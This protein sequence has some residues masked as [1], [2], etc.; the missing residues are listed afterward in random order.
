M[1]IIPTVRGLD[2]FVP[3]IVGGVGVK[4]IAGWIPLGKYAGPVAVAG[5][6][7]FLKNDVL[8]TLGGYELGK[9]LVDGGIGSTSGITTS[10]S[11]LG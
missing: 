5:M 2:G 11:I 4:L 8:M 10:D 1:A 9:S 6:G 7:Y 3:G